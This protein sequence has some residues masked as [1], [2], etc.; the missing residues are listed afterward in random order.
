MRR[1]QQTEIRRLYKRWTTR[2]DVLITTRTDGTGEVDAGAGEAAGIRTNSP[3]AGEIMARA[4]RADKEGLLHITA[5]SYV[6]G[7]TPMV[8]SFAGS[9]IKRTS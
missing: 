1:K 7:H 6:I 5:P 3:P 4:S 8:A 9:E 2:L